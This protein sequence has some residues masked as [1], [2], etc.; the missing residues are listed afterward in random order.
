MIV[1]RDLCDESQHV[2]TSL[3]EYNKWP[4]DKV[5][6]SGYAGPVKS[7]CVQELENLVHVHNFTQL[8]RKI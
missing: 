5:A 6:Q 1:V 2:L 7:R 3:P 4:H 8:S